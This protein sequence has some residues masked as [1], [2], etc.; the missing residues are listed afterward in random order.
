M[1]RYSVAF[2]KVLLKYY[3]DRIDVCNDKYDLLNCHLFD[4]VVNVLFL[5]F[6]KY[7]K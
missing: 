7:V 5:Q 3:L 4:I 1:S 6:N 2:A